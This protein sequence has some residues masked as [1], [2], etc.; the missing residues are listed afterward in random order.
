MVDSQAPPP[1][2][3]Q[4]VHEMVDEPAHQLPLPFGVDRPVLGQI[5]SRCG[6]RGPRALPPAIVSALEEE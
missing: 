3:T 1:S 4:G 5:C 6:K 2:C